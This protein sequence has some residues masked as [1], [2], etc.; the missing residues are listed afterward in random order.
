MANVKAVWTVEL[1]VTCPKCQ[2]RFDI[3]DESD[4]WE[5]AGVKHAGQEKEDY[6][7]AC[8]ECGHEFKCDFVY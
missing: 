5:F 1:N 2:S 4:F 3:T 7:T 8:P 6:E